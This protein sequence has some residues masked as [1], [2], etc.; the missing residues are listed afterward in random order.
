MHD[1]GRG[2]NPFPVFYFEIS[3]G[4]PHSLRTTAESLYMDK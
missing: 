3:F 4:L 2:G 1:G